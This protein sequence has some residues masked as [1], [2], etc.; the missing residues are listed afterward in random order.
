[1]PQTTSFFGLAALLIPVLLFTGYATDQLRSPRPLYESILRRSEGRDIA[2]QLA[3]VVLFGLVPAAAE[4]TALNAVMNGGQAGAGDTWFVAAALAF[5]MWSVV[6]AITWP[7]L[8]VSWKASRAVRIVFSVGALGC[9]LSSVEL[10]RSGVDLQ[11]STAKLKRT[12]DIHEAIPQPYETLVEK[13][14]VQE[15]RLRLR[16]PN[17][18]ASGQARIRKHIGDILDRRELLLD[19]LLAAEAD[20]Y[21][22]RERAGFPP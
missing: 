6:A 12:V 10:L 22:T 11:Q 19:Q 13:T 4:L 21:D 2:L 3:V 15:A 9:L 20:L 5:G 14:E 8:R 18:D 7:W 17:T 16:L 1:M